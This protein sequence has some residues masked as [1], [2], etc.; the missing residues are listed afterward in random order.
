MLPLYSFLGDPWGGVPPR[1]PAS[2]SSTPWEGEREKTT[3]S[4]ISLKC[5][6]SRGGRGEK[7]V[8]F[9][10][11]N[12]TPVPAFDKQCWVRL[13]KPWLQ[14]QMQG[15]QTPG[16][17]AGSHPKQYRWKRSVL[18]PLLIKPLLE[19]SIVCLLDI[20]ASP[21][22]CQ[23]YTSFKAD[24]WTQK[25]KCQVR[26]SYICQGTF[27]SNTPKCILNLLCW[28]TVSTQHSRPPHCLPGCILV[29]WQG[30]SPLSSA[31]EQWEAK[32][33]DNRL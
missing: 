20:M 16:S 33:D 14:P 7:S 28:I 17:T 10:H 15:S 3:A 4:L 25:N 21:K 6:S 12:W 24:P 19:P 8:S 13:I 31:E 26:C 23:W 32:K 9:W 18:Q 1:S 11:W 22:T 2:T 5:H 27:C 30:M 29:P